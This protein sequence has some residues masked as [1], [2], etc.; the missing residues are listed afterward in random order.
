[1]LQVRLL[2]QFDVRRDGAPIV[3][4]SRAAQSLLA[5]L[6]LTAGTLHRREKLAGM[7][8]PDSNEENA[9]KNLRHELWRLR[10]A[11]ELKTPREREV[12]ALLVDEISVGFDPQSDYWLD[13]SF[14]QKA[15][16]K[17]VSADQLIETLALYRGELLPGF[18]SDWV[19]LERERVHAALEQ[20]W[21]V[22]SSCSSKKN[23]G[24]RPWSGASV[25][26]RWGKHPSRRIAR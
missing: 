5:Y 17:Q 7:L 9:R 14:V 11:I 25:G 15:L 23:V 22:C 10:K 19:V 20:K 2:G 21:R 6:L 13:V 8:W 18:Y 26:L 24:R 12:P 16:P 4:P 3:I 1:M